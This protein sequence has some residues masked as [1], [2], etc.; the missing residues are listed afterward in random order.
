MSPALDDIDHVHVHAADRARADARSR[1]AL[2][3]HRARS[4]QA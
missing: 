3:M 2:D 4:L 1:D